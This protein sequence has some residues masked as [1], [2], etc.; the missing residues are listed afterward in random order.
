MQGYHWATDGKFFG[1]FKELEKVIYTVNCSTIYPWL[2][3]K[4]K[5]KVP[6]NTKNKIL[7]MFDTL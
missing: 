7:I 6:I 5:Q 3:S 4:I 1:Y 2:R